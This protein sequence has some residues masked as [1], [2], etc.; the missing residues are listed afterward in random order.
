MMATLGMTMTA[1][2]NY[3]QAGHVLCGDDDLL[4]STDCRNGEVPTVVAEPESESEPTP[5]SES[6]PTPESESEPTT[7]S[8]PEPETEPESESEPKGHGDS[9][10]E[11]ESELSS[12]AFVTASFTAL[13]V[14]ITA[15]IF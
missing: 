12:A 5:E 3:V 11:P 15:F 4:N 6:E 2:R 13:T 8:E 7:D 10:P 1:T 14:A 9:E